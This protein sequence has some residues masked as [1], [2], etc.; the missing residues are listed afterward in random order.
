MGQVI[1][2]GTQLELDTSIPANGTSGDTW[3]TISGVTSVDLGSNKV[4]THDNTDMGTAGKVRTFIDGLENAGDI[5]V[6]MNVKPGDATQTALTT[7]KDAGGLHY[8]KVIY[9]GAVRTC[10]FQGIITS[11]DEAIPDDKLPTQT[12]KIQIS[13]PKTWS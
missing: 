4:D 5:S 2:H 6:K 3:L 13:G 1:G 8:F 11:I 10:V 12:A 7:A 9:P